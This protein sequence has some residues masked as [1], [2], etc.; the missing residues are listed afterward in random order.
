MSQL[1][2]TPLYPHYA[3]YA[4]VRCI[5][6]GGWELPVQFYG[7]QKE[8]DAVRQHAGLFD[9]SHMGEFI[10]TGQ[11]AEAFLQKMTTNDVTRL[12][13]GQAQYTL[14]CRPEGG[15]VD[16]LL[17]YRFTADQYMLVVNAANTEADLAWLREHVIG[18]VT[19]DNISERTALLALQGPDAEHI[20]S[21]VTEAPVGRLQPFEFLRNAD[22]GGATALVSRTGYTGE[23]GFEIYV[24]ADEA[25][26]VWRALITAGQP[27]GLI[28]CGLGARDTLRF[29][30]RLPLY[31]QE[32]SPD[33]S[34]LE[35]GLGMFVKFD[36]G[37]FI[38]RE[39]LLR[40]KTEGVPRKLVGVEMVDRGIPRA[41]YPVYADGRKIGEVTTG[42]QSPT[43][44]RNLGLALIDAK[45]S[46]LGTEIWVDI[47]GKQLKA[48][49]VKTPFY[50]KRKP[51]KE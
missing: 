49:V 50:K 15:V 33:I 44:K 19:I 32:L 27:Y 8:H 34:P 39:A 20:L 2:R 46:E 28:P 22:V 9:V 24:P 37:D 30:A 14:M 41:H 38:G 51:E 1:K 10:V 43:L 42:T 47:R 40:Q 6:F 48:R 13:D 11:F 35:A 36:K 45:Y 23:D 26:V 18:D 16:D 7:I 21:R 4:S 12:K 31:G 17:V 29:E 25:S 3:E 5:D